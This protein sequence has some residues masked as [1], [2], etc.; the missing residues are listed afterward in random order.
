MSQTTS[1]EYKV[2]KSYR[3]D[4]AAPLTGTPALAELADELGCRIT[5]STT[6]AETDL[7][8]PQI[9]G[10]SRVDE[11][12]GA[13]IDQGMPVKLA[14]IVRSWKRQAIGKAK[15]AERTEDPAGKRMMEH[16]MMV[17]FNCIM[18]LTRAY[19]SPRPSDTQAPQ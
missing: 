10:V 11:L 4:S 14:E 6:P 13:A 17:L 2:D 8:Q 5:D 18:D 12:I 15:C 19:A 16:G 1:R 3:F 7:P 9:L